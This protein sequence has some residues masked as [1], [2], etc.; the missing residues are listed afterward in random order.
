MMLGQKLGYDTKQQRQ[1]V[2]LSGLRNDVLRG[3]RISEE[4]NQMFHNMMQY[5]HLQG[6]PYGPQW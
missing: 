5:F 2:E 3:T 1:G 4:K 6:P